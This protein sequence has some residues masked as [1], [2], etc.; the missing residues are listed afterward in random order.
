MYSSSSK[1]LQVLCTL[2]LDLVAAIAATLRIRFWY[3]LF[4]RT[5]PSFALLTSISLALRVVQAQ[6]T[7]KFVEVEPL[8]SGIAWCLSHDAW[9]MWRFQLSSAPILSPSTRA[10]SVLYRQCFFTPHSSF[11][12]SASLSLSQKATYWDSQFQLPARISSLNSEQ[13]WW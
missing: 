12:V 13:H 4:V 9:S 1:L 10:A 8:V 11:V 7:V 3:R 5:F 2:L 6:A